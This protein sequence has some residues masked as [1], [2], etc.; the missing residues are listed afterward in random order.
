MNLP[1]S[2][3]NLFGEPEDWQKDKTGGSD[4]QVFYLPSKNAWLKYGSHHIQQEAEILRFLQGKV[5]VP[6]LLFYEEVDGLQYMVTSTLIGNNFIHKEVLA[7]P[8]KLIDLLA[9]AVRSL[10][11][12][13][14]HA[15]PF[16]RRLEVKLNS[17]TFPDDVYA[18]LKQ[19]PPDEDLVFTHGDACLPN[20]FCQ[21]WRYT[22]CIDLAEAGIAD[23]W[24]DLSL[25][26]WS[27]Q[28][29]LGTI[30]WGKPF[31][32]VYGI[33]PDYQKIEYYLKL[34]MM[35]TLDVI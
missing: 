19:N 27:L 5:L 1:R 35:D 25:S 21:V 24:Q 16:N 11:S 26:L 33:Q 17:W 7:R 30:K 20:F 32:E 6:E 18:E 34:N 10:H 23:R 29:N 15:C 8:E 13:D 22:G 28:Y 2:L 14:I 12:L 3:T 9:K 4:A 31:L